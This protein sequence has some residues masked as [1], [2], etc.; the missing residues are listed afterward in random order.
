MVGFGMSEENVAAGIAHPASMICTD[1]GAVAFGAG[2]PHPRS[3]GTHPR[4][5][6]R[7]VRDL[8][9][10]PLET[11]IR[12]MTALPA[13]RMNFRDRG[14]IATGLAADLVVFDPSTIADRATFEAP[15]QYPTGI[16]HVLVN[17]TFVI[18]DGA[19]TGARPG[20]AVRPTRAR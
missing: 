11:A 10:C 14:M 2:S 12:K 13:A 1:S 3:Y 4:V 18:R 5:L 16:P 19:H 17:G 7:F 9:T 15:H 6:G 8:K 20:R